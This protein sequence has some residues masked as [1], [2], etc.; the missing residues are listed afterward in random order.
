MIEWIGVICGLSGTWILS[1]KLAAEAKWRRY[2]F[3][4]YLGSNFAIGY[5]SIH[6]HM[7]GVLAMQIVYTGFSVRGIWANS[8][9]IEKELRRGPWR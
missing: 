6:A 5:V 1:S 7:W 8:E 9:E 4:I 3:W 2:A